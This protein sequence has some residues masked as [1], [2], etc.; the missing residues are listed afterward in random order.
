MNFISPVL[1]SKFETLHSIR[2]RRINQSSQ[3]ISSGNRLASNPSQ[4]S[5]SYRISKRLE[6]ESKFSNSAK[7][8]LANAYT[9]AQQQANI[10]SHA[11]GII[12]KMNKLAY[13]ATDPISTN[14]DREIL[15]IEF[16]DLSKTL[17]S[18][19]FDRTFNKQLLDPQAADYVDKTVVFPDNET[20]SGV[21]S[22]KIDI[23]AISAKVKL[24]W[25]SY[26]SRDR[27]QLKQGDRWFFDSGEYSSNIGNGIRSETTGVQTMYGD[28]FEI[29]IQTNQVSLFQ[30]PDNKGNANSSLAPGYPKT[31][32][33]LGDSTVIDIVVNSPGPEGIV[34]SGTVDWSWSVSIEADQ[35][36][37]PKGIS[38]EQ[39]GM[40]ELKPL[41]FSTLKGYELTSRVS[42][43]D[44]LNRS[45]DELESLRTQIYTL[46]KTF[47][48]IEYKSDRAENKN[49]SQQVALSRISDTDFASEC[50]TL[51]KNLLLQEVSTHARLHSRL[52]ADSVL[53]LIS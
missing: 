35:V 6:M 29:D 52:S 27:I 21:Y 16:Q 39:G 14:L 49:I 32:S 47:S 37:G 10:I 25:N 12:S 38:D 50:T 43:S 28:Y 42:A 4:D 53:N 11:E 9:M 8:N 13:Q 46:S 45:Q 34:R 30:A 7:K 20:S 15:N 41:G 33:P 1:S 31:Q 19:M 36:E 44:A 40:Y 48:E 2:Q 3:R 23:S 26:T 17:E 51:A 18:L 24:W 22:K 5:G